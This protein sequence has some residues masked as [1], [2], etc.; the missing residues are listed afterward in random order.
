MTRARRLAAVLFLCGVVGGSVADRGTRAPEPYRDGEYWVLAGDF[1]V[2]S[3]FGDG[4][5]PPWELRREARRRG[6]DVIALTNHNHQASV[7]IDRWT[8][9]L[10]GSRAG[11][12]LAGDASDVLVMPGQ[13]ITAGRYHLI[14]VGIANTVDWTQT[15]AGAIAAVHA[16]GGAAIA[17]H[18][19]RWYW[20]AYDPRALAG[21]DGAEVAH[22]LVEGDE[23]L[24]DELIEFY[25]RVRAAHPSAAPIGSSDFH[26]RA[27]IGLCRTYV[28]ARERSAQGVVEAIRSGRTVAYDSTGHAFGDSSLVQ[29]AER[30]RRH[31]AARPAAPSWP[32]AASAM[33]VLLGLAGLILL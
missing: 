20:D 17:A 7:V 9:S 27:P 16:Q 2:H 8:F 31:D 10:A 25:E 29:M 22:P 13:E 3:F 6:L 24:R 23:E 18:P 1:H 21:L 14:G 19:T 28:F 5:L 12:F 4:V 11:S 30:R 33:A 15:A 26:V 32:A